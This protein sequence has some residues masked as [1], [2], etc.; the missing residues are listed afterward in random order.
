MADGTLSASKVENGSYFIS[1]A[2]TSNYVWTS[3]GS[4][5]GNW[6]KPEFIWT[7]DD[8]DFKPSDITLSN[9]EIRGYFTT[10]GGMTGS[11][12]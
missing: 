4:G 8:R 7:N 9:R 2:G 6:S 11:S 3:D 10:L 12:D 5:A 1:S